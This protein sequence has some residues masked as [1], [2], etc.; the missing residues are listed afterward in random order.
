MSFGGPLSRIISPKWIILS[1][2]FMVAIATI[3]VAAGGSQPEDY[4]P[5]IFPAFSLGSSGAM[6]AYSHTK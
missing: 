2:L 6:L 3:L 5:Y 1:G 4:W